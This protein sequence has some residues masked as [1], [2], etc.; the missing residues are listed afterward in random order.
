MTEPKAAD[1]DNAF[2]PDEVD[3]V[4]RDALKDT[5]KMSVDEIDAALKER[6]GQKKEEE[7]KQ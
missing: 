6:E 1:D 5:T 7:E 2:D 3:D 4:V